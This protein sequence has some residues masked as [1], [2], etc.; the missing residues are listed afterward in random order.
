MKKV[1]FS[2]D[3]IWANQILGL[4]RIIVGLF[5]IYHG[6]EVFDK[7]LME[8]YV[9]RD[10]FKEVSSARFLVY[11]GKGAELV[12]G[13]LLTIGFLTRIACIILAV[14]MLYITFVMGQGV[15]WYGDQHPFLFVLLAVIFFFV[16]PGS[17]SVDKNNR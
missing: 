8:G 17:F 1:F 2:A 5:M 12:G 4:I 16:G 14:T 15:I 9:T 10:V 3:P 13:I 7:E 6:W 11:L